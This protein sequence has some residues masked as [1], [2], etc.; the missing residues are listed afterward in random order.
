M[1]RTPFSISFYILRSRITTKGE[2]PVMLKITTRG[3]R[4]TLSTPLKVDPKKWS[5]TAGKATGRDRIS[6]EINHHIESIRVRIMQIHHWFEL[7][8]IPFT[9]Q[10]IIDNYQGKSEKPKKMLI[11][12]FTEHN[13]KCEKLEGK[14]FAAGTVERYRTSLKHTVEF[15]KHTYNKS[16]MPIEDVNHKFITDYEDYFKIVRKCS[17]NTTTKYLKN[18]KKIIRIALAN[19]YIQKDPFANIKFSLNKVEKA[20]ISESELRTIIQKDFGNN[21]LA[22]IRDFF[23]FSCFTD[24]SLM[25]NFLKTNSLQ[26]RISE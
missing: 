13:T 15:M 19:D 20:F 3:T 18:F 25:S 10:S 2:A 17:H 1:S 5:S 26:Q 14:E 12:L 22:Q 23:V 8:G 24:L 16:D 11:E 21:R 9:A 6:N 4:A 7:D